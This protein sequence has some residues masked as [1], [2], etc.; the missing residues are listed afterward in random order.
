MGRLAVKKL[1]KK[2]IEELL[3]E[4]DEG[5]G[6]PPTD[7]S[8]KW[9]VHPTT[10]RRYIRE[11]KSTP[12]VC[13]HFVRTKTSDKV[14]LRKILVE[15]RVKNVDKLISELDKHF[16]IQRREIEEDEDFPIIEV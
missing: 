6:L 7:L 12:S 8:K 1:S 5:F 16:T 3:K 11:N 10:I 4:Y 15:N 9:G 2:Q 14:L 13:S